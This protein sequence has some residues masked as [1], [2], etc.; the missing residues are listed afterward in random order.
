M[1]TTSFFDVISVVYDSELG[2]FD[3][4]SRKDK[5]MGMNENKLPFKDEYIEEWLSH[6]NIL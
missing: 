4:D 5:T 3:M 2:D 6:Q 1:D